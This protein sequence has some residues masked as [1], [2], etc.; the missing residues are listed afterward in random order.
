MNFVPAHLVVAPIVALIPPSRDPAHVAFLRRE[1]NVCCHEL[2]DNRSV[3][4]RQTQTFAA[5][6]LEQCDLLNCLI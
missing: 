5:I 3:Q 1:N 6:S 4:C 2:I